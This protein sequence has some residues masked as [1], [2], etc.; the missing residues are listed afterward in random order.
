MEDEIKS[1][2]VAPEFCVLQ[3]DGKVMEDPQKKRSD[4][5]SIL[6][7]GTQGYEQGKLLGVSE[8]VNSTGSSQSTTTFSRKVMGTDNIVGLS[9]L[10]QLLQTQEGRMVHA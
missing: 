5:L 8:I 3:W 6:I 2:F 1:S 9:D 4:R 10:T 7:S